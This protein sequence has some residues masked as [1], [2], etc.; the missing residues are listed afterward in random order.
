MPIYCNKFW[1]IIYSLLCTISQS[2]G[3]SAAGSHV[4]F[5]QSCY[6][7]SPSTTTQPYLLQPFPVARSQMHAAPLSYV[8]LVC[9]KPQLHRPRYSTLGQ[10]PFA[11]SRQPWSPILLAPILLDTNPG[12]ERSG[13]G[14][15]GCWGGGTPSSRCCSKLHKSELTE[16]EFKLGLFG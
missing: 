2:S 10:L 3:T 14:W 12:W 7:L 13:L 15:A 4:P 11:S 16:D 5:L 9:L 8:V 6:S 1:I